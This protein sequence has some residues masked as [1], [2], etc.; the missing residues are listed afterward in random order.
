MLETIEAIYENGT[1]KPLH[2]VDLPEGTPVRVNAD[3]VVPQSTAAEAQRKALRYVLTHL[4]DALSVGAPHLQNDCWR[5]DIHR[6]ASH[7][8]RGEL[9]LHA[10]TGEV[11]AWLPV[12]SD[13]AIS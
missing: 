6:R 4:G 2:P 1:F 5:F 8:L 11:V 12:A 10:E 3:V 13:L 9:R 7:E